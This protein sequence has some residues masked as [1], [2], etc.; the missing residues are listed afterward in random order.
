MSHP[1]TRSCLSWRRVLL[2][3]AIAAS[4]PCRHAASCVARFTLHK[5]PLNSWNTSLEWRE[6]DPIL[7]SPFRGF[8][9][10][11]APP[12]PSLFSFRKWSRYFGGHKW[13]ISPAA[14]ARTRKKELVFNQAQGHLHHLFFSSGWAQEKKKKKIEQQGRK[15]CKQNEV[16]TPGSGA[17][18]TFSKWQIIVFFHACKHCISIEM[19]SFC[20]SNR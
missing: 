10:E 15:R 17:L 19:A 3:I 2:S 14:E 8:Q 20:G 16:G 4:S 18:L 5:T 6:K 7:L 9:G 12:P 1:G 11:K 13:D